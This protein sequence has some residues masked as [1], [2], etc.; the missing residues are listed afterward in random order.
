MKNDSKTEGKKMRP[1]QVKHEISPN[2]FKVCLVFCLHRE[3]LLN[4][5]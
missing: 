1:P 3:G 5:I 2:K 4:K